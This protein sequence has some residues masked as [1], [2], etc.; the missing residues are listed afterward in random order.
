MAHMYYKAYVTQQMSLR[1]LFYWMRNV[2]ISFQEK[3]SRR[4]AF[5]RLLEMTKTN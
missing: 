3:I 4:L 1:V 5:A 2:F